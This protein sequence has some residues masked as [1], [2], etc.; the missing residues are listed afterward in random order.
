MLG[1]WSFFSTKQNS[2]LYYYYYY[3]YCTPDLISYCHT[4]YNIMDRQTCEYIRWHFISVRRYRVS[5]GG[6]KYT[7]YIYGLYSYYSMTSIFLHTYIFFYNWV[8]RWSWFIN[9]LRQ[10]VFY[11][12]VLKRENIFSQFLTIVLA[13]RDRAR[14]FFVFITYRNLL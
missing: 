4:L 9:F 6:K 12:V 3:Y 14:V 13:L 1:Y 11:N 5:F 2:P 10:F 7:K 8:R